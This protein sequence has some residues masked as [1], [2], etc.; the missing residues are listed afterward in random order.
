VDSGSKKKRTEGLT[1]GAD[2]VGFTFKTK[3]K[4]DDA[5]LLGYTHGHYDDDDDDDDVL[6][7]MF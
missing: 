3:D 1:K 6:T 4:V 5:E 7:C 2:Q